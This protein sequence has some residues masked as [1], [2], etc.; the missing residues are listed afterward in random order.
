[1]QEL[2]ADAFHGLTFGN[3]GILNMSPTQLQVLPPK[4]FDGLKL[5]QLSLQS[6]VLSRLHAETFHGLKFSWNGILDPWVP[7]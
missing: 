5:N 1:L 2:H 3:Y 7:S 4:V 6:N